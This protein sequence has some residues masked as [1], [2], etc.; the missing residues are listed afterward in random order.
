MLREMIWIWFVE[1]IKSLKMAMNFSTKEIWLLFFLRRIIALNLTMMLPLWISLKILFVLLK[2]LRVSMYKAKSQKLLWKKL[3][4]FCYF[5][6]IMNKYYLSVLFVS[7]FSYGFEVLDLCNLKNSSILLFVIY[8]LLCFIF[9]LGFFLWILW[10][11]SKKF[12]IN[13]CIFL[14]IIFLNFFHNL[15]LSIFLINLVFIF[16][17]ALLFRVVYR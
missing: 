8:F 11:Y 16:Q 5:T 15:S 12:L 6:I 3:I 13:F 10:N 17:T 7:K 4:N 2:F 9:L 1:R 14:F